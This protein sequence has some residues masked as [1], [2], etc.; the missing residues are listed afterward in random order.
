MVVEAPHIA[1]F[2]KKE[3]RVQTDP[4]SLRLEA[5]LFLDPHQFPPVTARQLPSSQSDL[6]S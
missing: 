4:F 3:D 1:R 2:L 5:H 6:E